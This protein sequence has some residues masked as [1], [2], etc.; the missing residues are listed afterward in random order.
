[1]S[2]QADTAL[3]KCSFR[4][5]PKF[6]KEYFPTLVLA[7]CL[8]RDSRWISSLLSSLLTLSP[9]VVVKPVLKL[10]IM[11]N[12]FTEEIGLQLAE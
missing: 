3:I 12:S 10:L 8:H 6:G 2:Y 5:L 9:Q 4:N 11:F 7:V 1:M